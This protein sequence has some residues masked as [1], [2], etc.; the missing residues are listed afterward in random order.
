MPVESGLSYN[1][2]GK[3]TFIIC[4]VLESNCKTGN[5]RTGFS[6]QRCSHGAGIQSAAEQYSN[7]YVTNAAQ[8]HCVVERFS[9]PNNWITW[10]IFPKPLS[11]FRKIPPAPN[12]YLPVAPD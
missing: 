5:T 6:R 1:L 11:F 7:R 12:L 3:W 8:F 10:Q 9:I 4:G 2:L